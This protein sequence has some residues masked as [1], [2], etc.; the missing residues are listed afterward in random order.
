MSEN[1]NTPNENWFAT[2]FDSPYYHILY[3]D[4]DD[5]EAQLFMDNLTNYLN[6]PEEAKIL[7]LACGKGRHAIYLNQ[8]GYEVTGVDLSPNSIEEASKSSNATLH[9]KVHDMREHTEEKYD[10]VFNLFT[11]FGYFEEESDN[12]KTLKAIQE[13]LTEY[14]FAVIDF[15][16]ANYVIDNLVPEETKTVDG[17][18]FHLKR[19][20]K[21]G[22]IFKEIQFEDQGQS[23]HFTEKVRALTL[24]D[25][26]T[27]ME[28]AGI[29]LL[30][31][32]GDYKLRKF[33]KNDSERLIMVFK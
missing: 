5:N 3:K 14:G 25:F 23:Y 13:S 27:M 16:N 26:E 33:Y 15:M 12:L 28:E 29:Y 19:Y 24:Q 6:L 17:I 20:V 31:I 8:L 32:F 21:D 11:S 22:H 7:D 18:D 1:R 4:R 2:W 30:E 9:F 10:A